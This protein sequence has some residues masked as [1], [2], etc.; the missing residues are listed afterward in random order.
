MEVSTEDAV[1][2]VR[3]YIN[4]DIGIT[5]DGDVQM[6]SGAV[7]ARNMLDEIAKELNDYKLAAGAEAQLA[8]EFK[9]QVQEMR[10]SNGLWVETRKELAEAKE[11][12][13]I[14]ESLDESVE[15]HRAEIWRDKANRLAEKGTAAKEFLRKLADED[16]R[17]TREQHLE[18]R[19]DMEEHFIEYVYAARK[20]IGEGG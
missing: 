2:I 1:E 12:I 13:A 3:G 7:Q 15:W 4:K 8:D 17:T 19:S 5:K 9:A 11:Q 10:V 6:V 20:L 14:L 16:I 18:G